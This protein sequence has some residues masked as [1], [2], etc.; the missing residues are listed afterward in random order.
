MTS[1]RLYFLIILSILVC[2][3]RG[4]AQTDTFVVRTDFENQGEQENYWAEKFFHEEYKKG[5]YQ[6]YGNHVKVENNTTFKFDSTVIHLVE[7]SKDLGSIFKLGILFPHLFIYNRTGRDTLK[8]GSI[9]ELQF[10]K[11]PPTRKRFR[12]WFYKKGFAN[13]TV[14]LFELTNELAS[15]L[16]D[17]ETFIKGASLTFV[18]HGWVII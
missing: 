7:D 10:F 13:P 3:I 2:T 5:N 18:K 12:L 15:P 6:K 4:N 16:T 8:I 9:E 17:L 1:M 11:L 14:Y